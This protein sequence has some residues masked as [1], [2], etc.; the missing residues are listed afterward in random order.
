MKINGKDYQ[1]FGKLK[2][3]NGNKFNRI[4][5]LATMFDELEAKLTNFIIRGN[6]TSDHARCA[7]ALRVMMQTGIRIGNEDSAE[8]YTTKPHPN[9]KAESVFTQT[10]GLTTLKPEHFSFILDRSAMTHTER[11]HISFLGK[12]SVQNDFVLSRELTDLVK[13]YFEKINDQTNVFNISAYE[14]TKFI[15]RSAGRQF[16]PKDFRTLRAN[17]VAWRKL[18]SL[19]SEPLPKTKTLFNAEVKAIA[20]HVSE[21]LNNTWGVC[22]KS[23]IDP[24]LWEYHLQN[25]WLTKI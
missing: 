23:Y 20:T 13:R 11:C 6:F 8:G 19:A 15:K 3:S 2:G 7:L 9:S 12:K 25:R 5:K 1:F 14:L 24:S 21:R 22:K 17:M 10:F 4:I 18:E 16:T